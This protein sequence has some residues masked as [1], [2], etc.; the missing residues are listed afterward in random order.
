MENIKVYK[1]P[2]IKDFVEI[3]GEEYLLED[4]LLSISEIENTKE[5]D[6]Y[7]DYSLRDYELSDYK[8]IELLCKLDLVKN[9]RG[10]RMANLYC[11]KNKEKL[12]NFKEK[13]L[14]LSNEL[15]K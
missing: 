9:Y 1:K 4:I 13:L 12:E 6:R 14:N 8:T 3:L 10:E 15:E 5:N 2:I 11:V 7:G